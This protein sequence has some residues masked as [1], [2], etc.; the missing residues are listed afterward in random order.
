MD[1]SVVNDSEALLGAGSW[2]V[3]L[4]EF[5][6]DRT[7]SYKPEKNLR[8]EAWAKECAL[9]S[10]SWKKKEKKVGGIQYGEKNPTEWKILGWG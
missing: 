7:V 9:E 3:F 4:S 5:W 6:A 2:V 8:Q 1:S 10:Q